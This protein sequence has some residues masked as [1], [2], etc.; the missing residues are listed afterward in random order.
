LGVFGKFTPEV[1]RIIPFL[2]QLVNYF[3]GAYGNTPL[4]ILKRGVL[5]YAPNDNWIKSKRLARLHPQGWRVRNGGRYRIGQ[6]AARAP[7]RIRMVERYAHLNSEHLAKAAFRLDS[8]NV[9]YVPATASPKL[10]DPVTL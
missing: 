5:S 2:N 6:P 7:S 3:V 4:V 9:S 8:V 1:D 10:D